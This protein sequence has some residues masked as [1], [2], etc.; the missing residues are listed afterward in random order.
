MCKIRTLATPMG[1]MEVWVPLKTLLALATVA[2]RGFVI[3]K[4]DTILH[5]CEILFVLSFYTCLIAN[6]PIKHQ[7]KHFAR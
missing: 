5:T 1:P 7:W 3:I 6:C 4:T 2:L